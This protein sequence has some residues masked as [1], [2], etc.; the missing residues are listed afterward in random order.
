MSE[1]IV[2]DPAELAPERVAL[3]LHAGAFQVGPE[4]PDWGDAQIAS[5]TAETARGELP[6][7]YRL[8][9]RTVTIPLLIQDGDEVTFDEARTML[10]QKVGLW[11]REGGVLKR[12][13]DGRATYLDVVGAT[14]KLGGGSLQAT[15]GFDHEASLVLETLPDWYGAERSS[16]AFDEMTRPAQT[17][18]CGDYDTE[19]LRD[20]PALYWPS[21]STSSAADVS[22][23][24]RNG[25]V[26]GAPAATV[27][28]PVVES[29]GDTGLELDGAND[30]IVSP[31]AAYANGQITLE[32]WFWRDS[33]SAEHTMFGGAGDANEPQLQAASGN[34]DVAWYSDG[35]ATPGTW[36][37]AFPGTGQWVHVALTFDDATNAT[38][39]FINGASKGTRSVAA[40][41]NAPG[42]FMV[43]AVRAAAIRPWDGRVAKVAVYDRVLGAARIREHYQAGRTGVV[44]GHL[45]GRVRLEATDLSGKDQ[46]GLLWGVRCRHYS[47]AAT[48]RLDYQASALDPLDA[49]AVATVGGLSVIQHTELGTDWTG[50]VGTNIGGTDWL[51]HTGSYRVWALARSPHGGDVKLRFV[52]DIGDL[53][54]PEENDPWR[55]PGANEWYLADLGE[56]RLDAAPIGTHRWQGHVQAKGVASGEDAQVYWV[57]LQPIDE[58]AGFLSAPSRTVQ[59][60]GDTL[61]RDGFTGTAASGTLNGRVAP[62]GG[63]HATSGATGDFQFADEPLSTDETVKRATVSDTGRGRL[64]VIG[65]TAYTDL[66]V[67]AQVHTTAI[68]LGVE[69]AVLSR[70]VDS[71]NYLEAVLYR[72][73]SLGAGQRWIR[74]TARIAGVETHLASALVGWGTNTWYTLTLTAFA[75]GRAVAELLS[76]PSGAVLATLTGE[77]T[78]LAASGALAAGKPGIRDMNSSAS[79]ATRYYDSILAQVP[80]RQ[81]AV[82]FASRAA[83]LR[84]DGIWRQDPNGVAYGPV[85]SPGGMLPRIPPSGLEDRP[86]EWFF[87]PTRGD[88]AV[89]PDYAGAAN[90][91]ARVHRRPSL[92]FTPPAGS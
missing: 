32:G 20:S 71:N 69:L 90:L 22:G 30:H 75:S 42:N 65:S 12:E 25:T 67:N 76:W 15:V 82:L 92:L 9:N 21:I 48:A 85:T 74:I 53:T 54:L 43:G 40:A 38:E 49:A 36:A 46:L 14:L 64:D 56:V 1:R 6:V 27:T 39:L 84:T 91:R 61:A 7:D 70:F 57:F 83:E 26:N 31:Y 58:G 62:V 10:Q 79:A 86:V 19:V 51:T 3:E 89:L 77:H 87:K 13:I 66:A 34:Q 88:L 33:T 59:G 60:L 52:Y 81:D 5:Y 73:G 63:T 18:L 78:A 50:L 4:G 55:F 17:V 72:I 28:S 11:Q 47:P 24:G 16:D 8:P 2:V 45:P 29:D 35:G 80:A 68:P 37:N 41:Y 23:H 44:D